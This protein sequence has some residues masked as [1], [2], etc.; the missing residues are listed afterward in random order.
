[1]GESLAEKAE[2]SKMTGKCRG[3]TKVDS[4]K[5]T[6]STRQR[7]YT[8]TGLFSVTS[9]IL[10]VDFLSG[11]I[12][13]SKVT[14]II[15]LHAE[16][17]TT[18]ELEPFIL[19]VYREK[20]KTGFLKAFSDVPE[21]F[22][23]GFSPL[24]TMLRNLFLRKAALYPRF[25]ADVAKSIEG[26]KKAEVIELEVTM[27]ESMRIIQ[28]AVMECTEASISELKK[29]NSGLEMDDWNMDNALHQNFHRIVR[30]QLDP[31]WHRTT[32]R[33]KQIVNDLF[34]LYGIL[35]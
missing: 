4:E 13:V 6:A 33:T 34:T 23:Y 28:N 18:K 32:P 5:L 26:R 12:D 16:K 15:V 2:V 30:R 1:M 22:T 3:L 14:G 19:R 17:A 25:Q 27:S 10:I 9:Q 8:E 31:V 21:F 35:Q 20:N 29:L 7:L 11:L 24:S